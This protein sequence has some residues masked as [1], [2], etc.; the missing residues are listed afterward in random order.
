M[1]M[2]EVKVDLDMLYKLMLEMIDGEV[3]DSN[4]AVVD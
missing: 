3:D 2:D 1:L 4:I